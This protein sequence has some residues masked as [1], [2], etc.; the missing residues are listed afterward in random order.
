LGSTR[1]GEILVIEFAAEE[2]PVQRFGFVPDTRVT[3]DAGVSPAST[4]TSAFIEI[5]E[6][7]VTRLTEVLV[8][9][10][11][12][13]ATFWRAEKDRFRYD[14]VTFRCTLIPASAQPFEKAWLEVQLGPREAGKGPIAYSMAPDRIVDVK[15]LSDSAKIGGDF[16]LIK[17]EAKS[18]TE[19][20]AEDYVLRAWREQ[21]AEPYW[22]FN[23]TETVPLTGT[24]KF[25]LVTRTP[26]DVEGSGKLTARAV[27]E[28]RTFYLFNRESPVGE[29]ASL[30][31]ALRR[32]GRRPA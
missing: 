9:G 12:E 16:K 6:P 10:D 26:V 14:Y 19:R 5:T 31:F 27:V 21:T 28:K 22:T 18:G 2:G 13:L 17:S 7:L 15:T 23:K 1:S 32:V 25:H 29:P 8:A 11:P 24:F 20:Q 30:T 3:R 4:L